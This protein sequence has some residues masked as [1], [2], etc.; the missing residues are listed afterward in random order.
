MRFSARPFLFDAPVRLER[1]VKTAGIVTY[2]IA[3]GLVIAAAYY[4]VLRQLGAHP[5]WDEKV[6][7]IGAPI[8]VFFA[9]LLRALKFRWATRLLTFL[10]L[11]AIAG[12][13][14]HQGRLQFAASFAE[15]TLAGQFWFIGWIA[16]TGCAAGFIAVLLTPRTFPKT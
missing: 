11:L 5:F 3:A 4:G 10:V 13:A 16:S 15:N 7:L 2:L 1:L 6:A 9:I 8:G 12:T 14:A